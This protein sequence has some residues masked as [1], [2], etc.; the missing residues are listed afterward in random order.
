[1]RFK[2]EIKGNIKYGGIGAGGQEDRRTSLH[3]GVLGVL[4]SSGDGRRAT[5]GGVLFLARTDRWM[6]RCRGMEGAGMG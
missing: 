3:L 5:G 4:R 2:I 1:M 6:G